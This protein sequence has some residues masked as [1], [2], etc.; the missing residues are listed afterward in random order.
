[1]MRYCCTRVRHPLILIIS[2]NTN[3]DNNLYL[4][5][6]SLFQQ[7]CIN[8]LLTCLTASNVNISLFLKSFIF[9]HMPKND[10][11]KFEE[12]INVIAFLIVTYTYIYVYMSKYLYIMSVIH[13][14]PI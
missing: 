3:L 11:L 12:V 1:M 5:L 6:K 14:H 10:K 9:E 7:D 2:I 4:L 8:I 13:S